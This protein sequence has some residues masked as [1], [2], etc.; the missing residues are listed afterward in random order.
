MDVV[1]AF[2][3]SNLDEQSYVH[4]QLGV[5]GCPR[6]VQ[7]NHSLYGH[8]QSPRC[9]S[10]AKNILPY[11]LHTYLP[12]SSG[13]TIPLYPP[14]AFYISFLLSN[15]WW[16]SGGSKHTPGVIY[17]MLFSGSLS[18]VQWGMGVATP[19]PVLLWFLPFGHVG[20]CA[21]HLGLCTFGKAD[22][23]LVRLY[24]IASSIPL[25]SSIMDFVPLESP[26]VALELFSRLFLSTYTYEH[27][28]FP[29]HVS[30]YNCSFRTFNCPFRNLSWFS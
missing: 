6:I 27:S 10:S 30:T 20:Q 3:G 28:F 2:L 21:A 8:N 19:T 16:P 23:C 1:T 15:L 24:Y 9:W 11:V 18:S 22:P 29:S 26:V 14:S 5:L 7:R 4:L 17:L 12:V 25:D 13:N